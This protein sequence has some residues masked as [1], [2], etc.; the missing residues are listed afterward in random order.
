[1]ESN[2]TGSANTFFIDSLIAGTGNETSARWE[3]IRSYAS[4]GRP[5]AAL[6]L[7]ESYASEK[8]DDLLRALSAAAEQ[9][10][11]YA[12]AVE[13][14]KLKSGGGDADR[15]AKLQQ[16]S[17]GAAQRATDLIVDPLNTR[18]P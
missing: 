9:V 7:A 5:F 6:K 14:E 1:M 16:L 12:K 15:V 10:G 17:E 4:N 13:F 8:D 2:G 18:K 3:L 11:D